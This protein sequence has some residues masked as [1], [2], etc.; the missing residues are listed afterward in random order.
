MRSPWDDALAKGPATAPVTIVGF[1]DLHCP[2][3]T[4]VVPTLSQLEAQDGDKVQREPP[5]RGL[6]KVEIA[7]ATSR[8]S[9]RISN[10]PSTL[11]P[12]PRAHRRSWRVPDA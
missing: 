12:H 9:C 1:S 3:C 7:T 6:E 4:Q 2:F 8:S 10:S 11:L 5:S